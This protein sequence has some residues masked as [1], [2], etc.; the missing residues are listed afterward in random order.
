M[1]TGCGH[2]TTAGSDASGDEAAGDAQTADSSAFDDATPDVAVD[3]ADAGMTCD[4]SHI[5]VANRGCILGVFL[6]QTAT[7]NLARLA[8]AAVD[9]WKFAGAH[10]NNNALCFALDTTSSPSTVAGADYDTWVCNTATAAD[11]NGGAADLTVARDLSGCTFADPD[12][13]TFKTDP[14]PTG[15]LGGYCI[16]FDNYS[17][18]VVVFDA[19][20]ALDATNYPYTGL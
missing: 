14:L 8:Q 6:D 18:N 4:A 17:I 16:G 15:S 1:A 9:C 5:S 10:G 19:C 11:F 3:A 7:K 12:N 2:D 20:A 13:T